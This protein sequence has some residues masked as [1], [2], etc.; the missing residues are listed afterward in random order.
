M[1]TSAQASGLLNLPIFIPANVYV[2]GLVC[3]TVIPA[4]VG[5]GVGGLVGALV[6]AQYLRPL[7]LSGAHTS[8]SQS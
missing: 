8:L 5:D 3:A 4:G 1:A 7:S 6:L 2:L